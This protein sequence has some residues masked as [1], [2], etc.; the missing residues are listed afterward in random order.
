[1]MVEGVEP[2][3]LFVY[4]AILALVAPLLYYVS[5][6]DKAWYEGMLHEDKVHPTPLGAQALYARVISDF[7][8]I[9][10]RV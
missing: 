3:D 5:D 9:T 8:E 1:M 7:P 4:T 6:K 2:R 10:V